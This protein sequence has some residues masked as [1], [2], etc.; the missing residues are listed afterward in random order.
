MANDEFADTQD[1]LMDVDN[2][3]FLDEEGISNES[4]DDINLTINVDPV[5]N[6][7]MVNFPIEQPSAKELRFK[8]NNVSSRS[9]AFDNSTKDNKLYPVRFLHLD[10]SKEFAQY[11]S[12]LFELYQGL[13]E[14]RKN[15]VPTIGL[16]KQT[17]RLEHFSIVNLA[18]HALVTE[19]EFYIESI[20]YTNKLQ[21]IGD[22]EEC[23]SILN[24]LKTIYFLTD[25]PEYKQED[26]L[27]SLIQTHT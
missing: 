23:L 13:G 5:S 2:L 19:L 4:D 3:D 17:S 11:V 8:Y 22:L 14:H 18:F 9:L 7:P 16:I 10:E 27:E 21:R 24:C 26:L 20:K 15:D 25:S 1:L 12:K 6:A